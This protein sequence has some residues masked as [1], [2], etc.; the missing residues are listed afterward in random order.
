VA[1]H[2]AALVDFDFLAITGTAEKPSGI[3]FEL[4]R[5]LRY[6]PHSGQAAKALPG[7]VSR[8]HD[9]PSQSFPRRH[10]LVTSLYTVLQKQR[11]QDGGIAREDARHASGLVIRDEKFSE[12]AIIEPTKGDM[13]AHPHGDDIKAL[14]PSTIWQPFTHA[15]PPAAPHTYTSTIR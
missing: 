6:Q 3:T 14:A 1:V 4:L 10:R 5:A 11:A 9:A 8:W 12:A 15:S 13:E 7:Y 2:H